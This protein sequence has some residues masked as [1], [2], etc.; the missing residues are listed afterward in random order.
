MLKNGLKLW[1][2]KTDDWVTEQPGTTRSFLP[3]RT[4]GGRLISFPVALTSA[5]NYV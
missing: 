1:G 3:L 4:I 5:P 2:L